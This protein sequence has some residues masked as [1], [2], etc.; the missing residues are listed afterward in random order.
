[1]WT[2][3]QG[4]HGTSGSGV[5]QERASG[6]YEL[7]GPVSRGA[8]T[9][10][11]C[12]TPTSPGMSQIAYSNLNYTQLAAEAADDC[13]PGPTDARLLL[14]LSCHRNFFLQAAARFHQWPAPSPCLT[15][16]L[17]QRLRHH[18]EPLLELV[19]NK[20]MALPMKA[21]KHA[22]YRFAA[23][24]LANK[25]GATLRVY[26]GSKN[27]GK[28]TLTGGESVGKK[29][30]AQLLSLEFE[31]PA[32]GE[33]T[34]VS[35]ADGVLVNGLALIEN[36]ALRSFELAN[37]RAGV[38]TL[39]M[40]QE[41]PVEPSRFVNTKLGLAAQ[42]E[43]GETMLFTQEALVAGN[44]YSMIF[45]TDSDESVRCGILDTTGK[46]HGA[47]CTSYNGYVEGSVQLPQGVQ[48]I[49]AFVRSEKRPLH[50]FKVAFKSW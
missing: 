34:L 23:T 7:L 37:D 32:D 10:R 31:A 13:L 16:G 29:Y 40:K 15:C 39:A 44:G 20:A 24:T 45:E 36:G 9:G 19:R 30:L 48:P 14:W 35:E 3:L 49:A 2:D 8:W 46:E 12:S 17:I 41:A 50:V 26:V 38:V 21:K 27:V 4:C 25:A 1:M 22:R 28:V 43:A 11:L 5:L 42:V 18:D 6:E 33:L 47:D